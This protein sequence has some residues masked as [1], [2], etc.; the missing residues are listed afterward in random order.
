[1]PIMEAGNRAIAFGAIGEAYR[2][3]HT[4]VRVDQSSS[5]KFDSDE[6]TYR[7]I[8]ALDAKVIDPSAIVALEM[9]A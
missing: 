3:R 9:G 8:M 6:L 1:M 4:A 7:I 2:I 5:F